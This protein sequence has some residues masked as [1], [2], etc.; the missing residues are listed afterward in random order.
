[1]KPGLIKQIFII[2]QGINHTFPFVRQKLVV[3]SQ[4]FCRNV[5]CSKALEV[6]KSNFEVIEHVHV[7]LNSSNNKTNDTAGIYRAPSH[8]V[9]A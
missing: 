1:M 3:D 6:S 4:F 5:L 8:G 2:F 7:K 9:R